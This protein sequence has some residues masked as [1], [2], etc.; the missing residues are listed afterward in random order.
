MRP[1]D[2]RTSNAGESG[3]AA[4]GTLLPPPPP[5]LPSSPERETA[6][7]SEGEAQ[8][9]ETAE[10]EGFPEGA[11]ANEREDSPSEEEG[12]AEATGSATDHFSKPLAPSKAVAVASLF[13]DPA[14]TQ[15]TTATDPSLE[16]PTAAAEAP[17]H[18]VES[19]ARSQSR[20]PSP[21]RH[22][23]SIIVVEEGASPFP[24]P[25]PSPSIEERESASPDGPRGL[26]ERRRSRAS[27]SCVVREGGGGER[28]L[29]EKV[30]GVEITIHGRVLSTFFS[31]LTFRHTISPLDA[32]S[33]AIAPSLA[34]ATRIAS[35]ELELEL[36]ELF[37]DDEEE[38]KEDRSTK[39][40]SVTLPTP[41]RC[42]S[43]CSA[44]SLVSAST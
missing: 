37:D 10:G 16:A 26:T 23:R 21:A 44:C 39:N 12:E 36:F 25:S 40:A 14:P 29:E 42:Q 35:A 19:S 8:A 18:E 33:S 13:A 5:I 9:T 34:A 4:A 43:I 28:E 7:S 1:G 15:A 11:T 2:A 32:S 24:F 22:A 3:R 17:P 41:L 38:E 6:P 20:A 27:R 31:F 30:E